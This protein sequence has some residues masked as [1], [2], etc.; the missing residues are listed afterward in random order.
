[1]LHDIRNVRIT[2]NNSSSFQFDYR[3]HRM[4]VLTNNMNE[5]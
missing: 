5:R 2:D 3:G 1:M 4:I